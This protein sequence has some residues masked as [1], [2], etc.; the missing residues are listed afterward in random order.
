MLRSL[1]GGTGTTD[2]PA[3][4][5]KERYRD[6]VSG[7]AR[8]EVVAPCI[9]GR[10]VWRRFQAKARS[11]GAVRRRHHRV[12]GIGRG[13]RSELARKVDEYA[14]LPAAARYRDLDAGRPG[15]GR[16]VGAWPGRCIRRRGSTGRRA[17]R[18]AGGRVV[19][20]T[21]TCHSEERQHSQQECS[22]YHHASIF[23]RTA[24]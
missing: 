5:H 20:P 15:V 17:R 12:V 23:P 3:C 2:R 8:D 14:G 10:P 11:E 18:C 7:R 16:N 19:R 22:S 9:K 21:A 13:A 6:L 24:P 1:A 4:L